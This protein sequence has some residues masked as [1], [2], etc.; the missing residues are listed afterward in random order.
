ML[1]IM[2]GDEVIG[3]CINCYNQNSNQK[4][5]AEYV[6]TETQI[7]KFCGQRKPCIISIDYERAEA[8]GK[9]KWFMMAGDLTGKS[10]G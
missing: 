7:C 3:I 4:I 2:K 9:F 10:V 8:D 5:T 1:E 6:V